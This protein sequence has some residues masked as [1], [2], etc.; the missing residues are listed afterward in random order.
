[1]LKGEHLD[2]TAPPVL[3]SALQEIR[4]GVTACMLGPPCSS[5][6]RARDRTRVIRT[7]RQPWGIHPRTLAENDKKACA[8][9]NVC[10]KSTLKHVRIS[11]GTR[12]PFIIENPLS[13]NMFVIPELI[14]IMNHKDV[15]VVDVEFCQFGASWKTKHQTCLWFDL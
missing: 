15:Q 6:S 9:G 7:R 4:A 12:T 11:F 5:F 13:S 1:M 8:V 3:R 14:R 2:C 10:L